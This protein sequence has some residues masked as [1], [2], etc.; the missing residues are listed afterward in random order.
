M[1]E[2]DLA[3]WIDDNIQS[4]QDQD[5][6]SQYLEDLFVEVVTLA[7]N[8][9]IEKPAKDMNDLIYTTIK[10][11][12]E[13][14]VYAGA[15]MKSKYS[16]DLMRY[17]GL[18]LLKSLTFNT[19]EKMEAFQKAYDKYIDEL[20]HKIPHTANSS[21]PALLKE[22]FDILRDIKTYYPDLENYEDDESREKGKRLAEIYHQLM[23]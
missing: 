16:T 20:D 15:H 22:F 9:K 4:A 19:E 21:Q 17:G 18:T 7:G 12:D 14:W 8:E 11:I 10:R 5:S 23:G 6:I 13:L 3:K 2:L 1:S